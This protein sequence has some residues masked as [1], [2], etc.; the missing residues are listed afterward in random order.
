M[1]NF[2]QLVAAGLTVLA[3]AGF[4]QADVVQSEAWA[5]DG[6]GSR[7]YFLNSSGFTTTT[8]RINDAGRLD[9]FAFYLLDDSLPGAGT[10]T[11]NFSFWEGSAG[12]PGSSQLETLSITEADVAA[13]S[14]VTSEL[15]F[16]FFEVVLDLSGFDVR[17]DAGET[18]SLSA[19]V[20]G[21]GNYIQVG[22]GRTT[23]PGFTYGTNPGFAPYVNR[24][25]S[26][27]APGGTG[28]V[29]FSNSFAVFVDN[30]PDGGVDPV[31]PSVVPL[32][33]GLPLLLAGLGSFVVMRRR[34]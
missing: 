3:T 13:S 7:G 24:T 19:T 12:F 23:R 16:S 17:V 31:D 2:R 27:V 25:F 26:T 34:A 1:Q 15:G 9:S 32:P 14:T 4:A 33:A 18:Y 5:P 8:F 21:T 10:G 22:T 29:G 28:S 20:A 11:I 30:D 6:E